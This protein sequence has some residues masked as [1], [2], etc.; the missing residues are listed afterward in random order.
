[1]CGITGVLA[2]NEVGRWSSLI[3]VSEATNQL[4]HRG[5]DTGRLYNDY[6]GALGHRR[7]AIIDLSSEGWQPMSDP[8]ERYTLVFNGEIY[9]FK[10]IRKR[11]VAKG[12]EFKSDSDTEVLLH[13]YIEKKEAALEELDGFFSFAVF[14]KDEN[15]LFLARD[16]FGIKPLLYYYDEDRFIFAS[17]MKSLLSY[18]I[19]KE[20]DYASLRQYFQ[21]HYIQFTISHFNLIIH[22]IDFFF[23]NFQIFINIKNLL[24]QNIRKHQKISNTFIKFHIFFFINIIFQKFQTFFTL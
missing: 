2:F 11:L 4:S 21:L 15:T 8:T 18:N 19:P 12:I 22:C 20:V 3:K 13:L 7:L 6:F 17:E 5:P 14:D 10:S 24:F 1:M 23:I 16:R 9:N